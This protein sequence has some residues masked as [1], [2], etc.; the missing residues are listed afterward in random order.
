MMMMFER[1]TAD[2]LFV[3]RKERDGGFLL[4]GWQ[5]GSLSI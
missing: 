2:G 3:E 5:I 1:C 4:S